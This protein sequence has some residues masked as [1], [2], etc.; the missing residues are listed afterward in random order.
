MDCIVQSV[1]HCLAAGLCRVLS[2][3]VTYRLADRLPQ[4]LM[5]T[6]SFCGCLTCTAYSVVLQVYNCMFMYV[7]LVLSSLVGLFLG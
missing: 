3:K 4:M 2:E 5:L 1:W 7:T 6:V